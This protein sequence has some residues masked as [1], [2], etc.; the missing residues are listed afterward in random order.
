MTKIIKE[1]TDSEEDESEV[2]SISNHDSD[3]EIEEDNFP[4]IINHFFTNQEGEN[5]AEIL[6]QMRKSL[7]MHNKLIFKFLKAAES[8]K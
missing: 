6:S 1:D 2:E 4:N 7:D 8:T 3:E 5:I